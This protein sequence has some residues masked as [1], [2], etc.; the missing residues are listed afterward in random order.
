MRILFLNQF[1]WPDT[2]ATGQ[3]LSDVAEHLA[4]SGE[5]VGVIC[6]SANYG[7]FNSSP[8][9]RVAITRLN[10][11]KLARRVAGRMGTY[12]SFLAGSL[13][14]GLCGPK[15]DLVV[16][17]TTPPL[18]SLVGLAI[19]RW[20]GARHII[21]EMDIY[22]DIAADLGVLKPGGFAAKALGWLADV[23]RNRADRVIVLG[24]CMR[25]RLLTHG[26]PND[27]ICVAENWADSDALPG[28]HRHG[29]PAAPGAS[30]A[31]SVLYSGNFGRAHD[32][33]TIAGA[34]AELKGGEAFR[35]VFAGG[36]SRQAWLRSF[37]E[38]NGVENARFLPYCERGE[39]SARLA[40]GHVG[41][42]TQQPA[43]IGA[44]VPSKIY[45]I[46]AAGRP[47]LF[48][49]PRESTIADII[50]RWGCG[51][52]IDCGDVGGLVTL[53]RYLGEHREVVHAA[54]VRAHQAF[55]SR[56]QRSLG[57]ARWAAVLHAGTEE[58]TAIARQAASALK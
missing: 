41:L 56:Y 14:H 48:V 38:S 20:R 39:L 13:W 45:G 35:F 50:E 3:L 43:S 12:L 25:R 2:A 32:A 44:V 11:A 8:R 19:Q 26:L 1:F 16:T 54:G 28:A 57:V 55:V 24:E 49:G 29:E 15:P 10:D 47:V 9:P 30:G 7:G 37:C 5:S 33:E 58:K 52:Q 36:G 23:S 40:S 4:A 21:W 18:L 51:W 34:M 53:L 42:V 6:G 46:L 17:L 22:P 27:K 31:F